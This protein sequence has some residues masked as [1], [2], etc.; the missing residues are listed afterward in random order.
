[1]KQT[2]KLQDIFSTGL[3]SRSRA[4]DLR[5]HIMDNADEIELNFEGINFMSRSFADEICNMIDDMKEKKFMFTNQIEEVF[6]MMTKVQESRS[7]ERK[8][9]IKHAKVYEFNDMESLSKY[10]LTI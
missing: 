1:M 10:L 8:R 4:V 5:T 2:I 6:I 9:G 7:R 3:Y